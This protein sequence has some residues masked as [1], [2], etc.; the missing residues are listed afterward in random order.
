MTP[1]DKALR[2]YAVTG[3]NDTLGADIWLHLSHGYVVSTPEAFA[4]VRPVWSHWPREWLD[5]VAR[6]D[7]GGDCWYIWCLT[8]SLAVAASWLPAPK[9]WLAFARRGSPRLVSWN[10]LSHEITR[11][12]RSNQ[13]AKGRS[14]TVSGA[15]RGANADDEGSSG[16]SGKHQNPNIP[17]CIA[18]GSS[19]P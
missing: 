18:P 19:I 4:M 1:W 8:G 14:H 7:A 15:I 12:F 6:T 17:A 16:S 9:K 2:L 10:T 13:R 11:Q 5:D 3:N